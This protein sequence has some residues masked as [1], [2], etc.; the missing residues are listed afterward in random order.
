[1]HESSLVRSLLTQVGD[2]ARAHPGHRVCSVEVSIG[3]LAGAEPTLFSEAFQRLAPC[4]VAA[5]ANLVVE[6]TPLTARCERCHETFATQDIRFVCPACGEPRIVIL[7]GDRVVLESVTFE[8]P[9]SAADS[10]PDN[11]HEARDGDS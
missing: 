3:P 4:S 10:S 5:G 6:C 11:L 8:P 9:P 2:L 7:S 1:M